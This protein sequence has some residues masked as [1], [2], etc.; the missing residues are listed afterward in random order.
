MARR[1]SRFLMCGHFSDSG[2]EQAAK[3]LP[4]SAG[5]S[6]TYAVII[7]LDAIFNDVALEEA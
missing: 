3:P 4:R 1:S 5:F 6:V 2:H 7:A